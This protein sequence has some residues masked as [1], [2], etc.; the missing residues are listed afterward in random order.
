MVGPK[1][2]GWFAEGHRSCC[3]TAAF[4][5]LA[6]RHLSTGVPSNTCLPLLDPQDDDWESPYTK[7]AIAEGLDLP[8]WEKVITSGIK[9]GKV[10]LGKL[11]GGKTDDI[12]VLVA[13]VGQEGTKGPAA[14]TMAPAASL[15]IAASPQAAVA[16]AAASGVAAGSEQGTALGSMGSK[17]GESSMDTEA[18]A[19]GVSQDTQEEAKAW[20]KAWRERK[21]DA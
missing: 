1:P 17:D 11:R 19:E 4:S 15:E 14:I 9:G 16:G 2:P 6:P 10:E 8:W 7:A 3:P 18:S 20:I 13:V 12:T 5:A 21:T